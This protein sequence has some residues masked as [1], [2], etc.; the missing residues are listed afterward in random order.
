MPRAARPPSCRR[1]SRCWR[2]TTATAGCWRKSGRD[3][4][5]EIAL[6]PLETIPDG[7]VLLQT[8]LETDG[9]DRHRLACAASRFRPAEYIVVVGAD[10]E[11]MDEELAFLRGILAYIVPIALVHCRHRRLVPGAPEPVAGGGDGRSRAADRRRESERAPAGRQ[12]ARRARPPGGDVQRAARPAGSVA[13]PAA[14]VHGRRVPRAADAGGDDADRGQRGAAAGRTATKPNT[15]RRCEIVEQQAARLSRVVDDMFTLA[16]ADAGNYPMRMT[17]MYLDEV[18]DEVVR[19]ARV[20]ASTEERVDRTDDRPVGGVHRRRGADPPDD[21]QSDRQRRPARAGRQHGA[22]RARRDRD[23]LRHRASRIR[24]RASRRDP[25]A[26][27][28]AL[29]S[30]RRRAPIAD[31]H[32]GAGLGLALA[33]WIASAHGGDVVLARS[34]PSGLD[35]RHLAA[36]A[37]LSYLFDQLTRSWRWPGPWVASELTQ[38]GVAT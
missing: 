38:Q 10:L 4:D 8:V 25:P 2:S 27:L 17:P 9:D 23:R 14:A 32:D 16:R 29:L 35:V 6:P 36:V 22:R 20:M 5:L 18:I 28:R 13:R 11:P 24:G 3:G 37:R 15:A 31:A 1:A 12:S 34:S 33:R 7:E 19:A 26:H 21:R 30:R